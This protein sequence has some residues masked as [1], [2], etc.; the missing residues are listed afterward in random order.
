MAPMST[1]TGYRLLHRAAALALFLGALSACDSIK[2]GA[3][4]Y[5]D[6]SKPGV[7]RQE[8]IAVINQCR[9]QVDQTRGSAV[10]RSAHMGRERI[11]DCLKRRGFTKRRRPAGR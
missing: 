8:T 11:E 10:T 4:W 1:E 5:D 9:Q 2:F 7:S 6:Y 3:D